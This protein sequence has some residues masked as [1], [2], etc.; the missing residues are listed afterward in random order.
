MAVSPLCLSTLIFKTLAR[1]TIVIARKLQNFVVV[2]EASVRVLMCIKIYLDLTQKKLLVN[3]F[4][5]GFT[6]GKHV[7]KRSRVGDK[8]CK[9]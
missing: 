4:G 1:P 3:I 9:Q 5:L 6:T 7:S 2:L 8:K